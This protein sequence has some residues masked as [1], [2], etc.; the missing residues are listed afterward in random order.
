MF[1]DLK[2][3]IVSGQARNLS[4]E[5]NSIK[6]KGNSRISMCSHDIRQMTKQTK[7]KD[8]VRRWAIVAVVGDWRSAE[9]QLCGQSESISHQ[10]PITN[11]NTELYSSEW[12]ATP[13]CWAIHL[14][15]L[16]LGEWYSFG[17][18]QDAMRSHS[19]VESL[20]KGVPEA[21]CVEVSSF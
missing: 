5:T 12:Q 11:G 9:E 1:K 17:H 14:A 4:M 3:N 10:S 7:C 8:K 21:D 2:E 15:W 18:L 20:Q 13:F 19:S 16:T 6:L